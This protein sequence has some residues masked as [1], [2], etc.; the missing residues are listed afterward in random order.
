MDKAGFD[1]VLIN[2]SKNWK[3]GQGKKFN[4]TKDQVVHIPNNLKNFK[5]GLGWDT[6]SDVDASIILL[7][8]TGS[9]IETI[10]F[11]NLNFRKA[12]VHSGDNLTG[13]GEG[14]DEVITINLDDL[15]ES[16]ES[17]WP[18]ITIFSTHKFN[19]IKGA[20]CRIFD[21]ETK[22]EF[23]KYN[24]SEITDMTSNGCIVASLHKYEDSWALKA[25]GYYT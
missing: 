16:V 23:V 24:L 7:D 10:Y 17:I 4:I 2:E 11:G 13:E 12:V 19:E 6:V 25:R 3:P 1:S 8:K 21:G 5:F 14:D 9:L 22:S 15:P 18:V 20:F